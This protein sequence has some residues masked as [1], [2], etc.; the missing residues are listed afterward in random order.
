[1]VFTILTGENWDQTMITFRHTH[2]Y[3]SIVY[4]FSLIIIGVMIFLNL[5]LAILLEN[6]D[7]EEEEQE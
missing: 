3:L 4:F 2:G 5:F 6:F 7:V 1:V